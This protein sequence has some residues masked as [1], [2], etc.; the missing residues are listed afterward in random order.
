[1]SAYNVSYMDFL[2]E[3]SNSLMSEPIKSSGLLSEEDLKQEMLARAE[4]RTSSTV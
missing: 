2:Q 3:A 1:M 4:R